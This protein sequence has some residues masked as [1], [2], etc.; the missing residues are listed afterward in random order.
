M[1]IY[2]RVRFKGW[3]F[4]K[5]ELVPLVNLLLSVT[6]S[7]CVDPNTVGYRKVIHWIKDFIPSTVL[8]K[9]HES[10]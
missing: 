4:K 3:F 2:I 1:L 6:K 8:H 9:E 5:M 7:E 10:F